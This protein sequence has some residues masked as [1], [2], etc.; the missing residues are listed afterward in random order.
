VKSKWG[1]EVFKK[2]PRGKQEFIRFGYDWPHKWFLQFM[3]QRAE[4][5]W[6]GKKD[7]GGLGLME[8]GF[9]KSGRWFKKQ[10]SMRGQG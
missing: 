4:K 1:P 8:N 2:R 10:K 6:S 5:Y 3:Q 9:A 7:K